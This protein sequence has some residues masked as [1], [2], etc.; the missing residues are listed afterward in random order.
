[1]LIVPM[2][3]VDNIID[4]IFPKICFISDVKL[5][6]DNS[7]PFVHDREIKSLERINSFDLSELQKKINADYSF[8]L[9]TFRENDNF[10]KIIYQLKYGGMKRL[11]IYMGKILGQELH[12]YVNK[13]NITS[14]DVIM[15]IPLYK[16]KLRERGYNQ[17][18]YLC[19]GVNEIFHTKVINDIVHRKRNTK[20]QSKLNN[21]QRTQN[22]K[23]AFEIDDKAAEIFEKNIILIDDVVTTGSTLNEVIR[24]LK[25]SHSGKILVCTLAMAR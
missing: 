14:F 25:D 4:F 13:L 2:E 23:D 10:S 17:S 16:T 1:M 3:I 20:T 5:E 11:G 9:F 21:Q 8:S 18:E 15:P 12:D 19:E 22:V 6:K 24:I 7:N